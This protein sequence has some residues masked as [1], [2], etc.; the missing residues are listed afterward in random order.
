MGVVEVDSV[1]KPAFEVWDS[2][3]AVSLREQRSQAGT[4]PSRRSDCDPAPP[5]AASVAPT[6]RNLR[7][8]KSRH[9]LNPQ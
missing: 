2:I 5:P 4:P 8:V 7:V 3:Q 1:P 9:T 6:R